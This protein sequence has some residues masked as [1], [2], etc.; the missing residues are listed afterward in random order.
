MTEEIAPQF[1]LHT[2]ELTEAQV[3][4]V[5]AVAAHCERAA[6][7]LP[8]GYAALL[9]EVYRLLNRE[10]HAYDGEHLWLAMTG[11][12]HSGSSRSGQNDG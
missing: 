1:E 9:M 11:G 2:V 3:N 12:D 10:L 5:A 7:Q 6:R 8:P 4:V